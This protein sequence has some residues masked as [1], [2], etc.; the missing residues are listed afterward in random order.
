VRTAQV[1]WWYQDS[2]RQPF[3]AFRPPAAQHIT[4]GK[5]CHA[6]PEP[7]RA[8]AFNFAGLV[9]AFHNQNSLEHFALEIVA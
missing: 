9:C 2:D 4:P 1:N 3:A 6:R 8:G 5:G 7:V